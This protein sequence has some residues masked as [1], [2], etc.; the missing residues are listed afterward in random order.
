MWINRFLSDEPNSPSS[1]RILGTLCVFTLCFTLIYGIFSKS[2]SQPSDALVNTIGLLA[3]GLLGLTSVD[4]YNML[5]KKIE[6]NKDEE[7]PSSDQ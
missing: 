5:K 3:F 7:Y 4:K 6:K 1:K 2:V